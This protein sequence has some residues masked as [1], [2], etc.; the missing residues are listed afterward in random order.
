METMADE[1]VREQQAE[2]DDDGLCHTYCECD[3][4]IALCGAEVATAEEVDE[5]IVPADA[6]LCVV[7]EDLDG[8]PCQRCGR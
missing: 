4:D 3:E 5:F 6:L 2:D 8:R 7:C 1:L